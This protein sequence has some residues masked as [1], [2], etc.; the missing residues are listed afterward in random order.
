MIN[1]INS[2]F[3]NY[4]PYINGWED[5]KRAS[6]T[7]PLVLKEDK[8]H[9]L[10]EVRSKT[11]RHQ[12]NEICFPGGKMEANESPLDTA[13]RE[14]CEEIGINKNN[15]N[16]ICP[17]DIFISPFNILIHP[18]LI[19]L[20]DISNINTNKDEVESIFLVPLDYLLNAEP[21]SFNNAVNITPHDNFPYDLIP[22]KKDY[23]FSTGSY[24]VLFYNYNEYVIWGLTAKIL[25]NFISTL[26]EKNYQLT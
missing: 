6:V 2:I 13:I 17:L 20:K 1:N 25:Y 21:I 19:E 10:F 9:L 22:N 11:L 15:I 24:E 3:K 18:F 26:K 7:I 16:V 5:Y 23:K 4:T 12:P 14:T 8:I